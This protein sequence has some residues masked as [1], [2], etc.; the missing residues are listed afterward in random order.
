MKNF[1]LN[2][3]LWISYTFSLK[4]RKLTWILGMLLPLFPAH[5]YAYI[6]L[7]E[8]FLY[9]GSSSG[10]IYK[11]G[12]YYAYLFKGILGYSC[13][14]FIALVSVSNTL[15]SILVIL[16]GSVLANL[17]VL[18]LV[19]EAFLNE[20]GMKLIDRYSKLSKIK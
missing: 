11:W 20:G 3:N 8:P 10:K 19:Y 18:C 14:Y 17:F 13:L 7:L 6:C 5:I 9:S 4:S 16:I 15:S 2:I 12:Y 1:I